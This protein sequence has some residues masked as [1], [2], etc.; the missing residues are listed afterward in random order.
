MQPD[1]KNWLP[2]GMLYAL[3]GTTAA[4]FGGTLFS[5]RNYS[6]FQPRLRIP[7]SLLLSA[8]TVAAGLASVWAVS[9]YRAFS[10]NGKRRLAKDI[11]EGTAT[12]IELPDHGIGLDI[13]CGSGALTIACAKRNPQGEMV[14]I[15]RWGKEYASFSRQL[16]EQNAVA[17]CAINVRFEPGDAVHLDYPDETFDAVTSN[18]VF[19]NIKRKSQSALFREA[20]RVLKKGGIFSIHDIIPPREHAD[21]EALIEELKAD[22]YQEINLIPTGHGFFMPYG[23]ARRLMLQNSFLLVG[24]K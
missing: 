15:D 11:I 22:G 2:K 5:L 12:Y 10:Y 4:A 9:A 24:K 1:Y 20:L 17:E 6:N 13:G 7:L 19:H 3:F 8:T 18:Y 14:G 23:E 16:C 21:V